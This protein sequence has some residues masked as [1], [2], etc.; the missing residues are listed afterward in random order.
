M[1]KLVSLIKACMTSDMNL[2]KVSSK[3]RGKG[4]IVLPI[5]LAIYLMGYI[6]GISFM[7]FKELDVDGNAY[8]LLS[9]FAFI[10]TLL[11]FIEG[12]YKTS[13]LIFNAKDDDLLLSLPI[14]R[15]TVIFIRL[16]KFYVFELLYNS[17]FLYSI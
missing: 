7:L 12:I 10:I 5:I 8:V 11:T 15:S 2:F 1:K 9:V 17:V 3:K 4:N 13:S 14:K 16:F 6:G